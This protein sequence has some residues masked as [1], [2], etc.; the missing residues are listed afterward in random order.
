[1]KSSKHVKTCFVTGNDGFDD[2]LT[3]IYCF[4]NKKKLLDK[5]PQKRTLW[6][7]RNYFRI[8]NN[9]ST[10]HNEALPFRFQSSALVG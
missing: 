4:L 3:Y 8:S 6:Y 10:N 1:M 9:I 7:V 5:N 2:K